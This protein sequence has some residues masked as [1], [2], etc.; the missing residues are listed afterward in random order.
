MN[1]III[2]TGK[3]GVGKSSVAAAHAL[4]SAKKGNKTL[5]VSADTAHNLGDIF[6]VQIG[7]K[8]TKILENLD[9]LELDSDV[10]KKEMFPDVKNT[11][12]NLMG[13]SGLSLNNINENFSLPGFENLFSLLKIKEIYETKQYDHIIVDCAPTGETLS[14]LKLPELL[15]WYMEKFFPVGKKIVRVLSPVSKLAYKV[16]LPS[17]KTMDS[18]ELI[19]QNLVQLQEL[20]KN[21]EVCSVRL[22]CIPEKMI[23]EET[24]RNFMYLNLY[25]YQLD[26]VFINRIITDEVKNPFMQNWKKIQSKYIKELEEVFYDTPIAKIPWYPKEIVGESAL[27]LV[28]NTIENLPDLFSVKK[29]TQNEEYLPCEDGYILKIQLPFVKEDELNIHHNAL[30]INIKINN[31]NRCIPLP[32]ILRK[33][34]IIDTKLENGSLCIHFQVEKNKEEQS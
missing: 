14:L 11:M 7:S 12:L 20:L 9:A 23:V 21:N 24:K 26:A 19:H 4:S 30:D 6:K 13:T 27:D 25:K 29:V 5:L 28:C 10:V 22:V 16:T 31:V 33:S 32:N 34:Q 17:A 2:F 8:I 18:I 15:G 3:G 1:R